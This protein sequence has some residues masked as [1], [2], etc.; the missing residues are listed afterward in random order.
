MNDQFDDFLLIFISRN[1]A[2][3]ND[4]IL[5]KIMQINALH[6]VVNMNTL[7]HKIGAVLRG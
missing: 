2:A 4:H 1:G 6:G 3:L 5:H 7:H